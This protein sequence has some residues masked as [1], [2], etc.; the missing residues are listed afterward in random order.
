MRMHAFEKEN[1]KGL[2]GYNMHS[3]GKVYLL[4]METISQ[5]CFMWIG[6]VR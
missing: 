2:P 3:E 1:K 6:T 5:M 4:S